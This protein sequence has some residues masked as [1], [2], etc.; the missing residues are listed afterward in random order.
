[1]EIGQEEDMKVNHDENESE[2][3]EIGQQ[4]DMKVNHDENESEKMQEN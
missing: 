2:K 1:M 3:M 4:E